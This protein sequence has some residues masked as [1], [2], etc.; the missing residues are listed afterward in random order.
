MIVAPSLSSGEAFCTVKYTPRAFVLKVLSKCSTV[1][2]G[3]ST[4]S[5]MPAGCY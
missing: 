5:T 4:V 3:F 1:A 2:A